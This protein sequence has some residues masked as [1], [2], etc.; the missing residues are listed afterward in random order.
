MTRSCP[1]R[2]IDRD[3][4]YLWN[5]FRHYKAGHLYAPGG[6]SSQPALYLSAMQLIEGALNDDR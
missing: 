4:V 2:L 3:T 1:R 5:L 6:V